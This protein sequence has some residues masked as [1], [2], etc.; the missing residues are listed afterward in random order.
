MHK[1][2]AALCDGYFRGKCKFFIVFTNS[3]SNKI[4]CRVYQR[5]YVGFRGRLVQVSTQLSQQNLYINILLVWIVVFA[6]VYI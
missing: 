3:D 4:N 5:F 6:I 1:V 2:H